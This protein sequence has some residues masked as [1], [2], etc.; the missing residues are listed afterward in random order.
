MKRIGWLVVAA[1]ALTVS[2]GC[3]K[4]ARARR[5]A[6]LNRVQLQTAKKE[7]EAAPTPVKKNEVA[8]EYFDTAEPLV[9]VV[10]DYM[11]GR[12]PSGPKPGTEESAK[13]PEPVKTESQ[14]TPP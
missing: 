14:P 8:K 10:D 3:G 9:G 1:L 13:K 4:D 5:A 2:T 7:F 11:Q 6:S 12:K